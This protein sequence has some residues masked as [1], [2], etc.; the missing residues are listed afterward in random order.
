MTII[1]NQTIRKN[2]YISNPN[3][4][5][6]KINALVNQLGRK[7]EMATPQRNYATFNLPV[8]KQLLNYREKAIPSICSI[9]KVSQNEKQ[10]TESLYV[11]DRMIEA[12]VKGVEKTYPT[13]SRF[14]NTKSPTIQTMLAGIY[15]KTQV[16]DAFG[17]LCRMLIR[18]TFTPPVNAHFDPDEEIGGA[19]LDYIRNKGATSQYTK[20]NNLPTSKYIY[21]C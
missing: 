18:N 7:V 10:I 9:L 20:E 16:P 19:I 3:N 2:N 14:N 15:R 4:E 5:I 21:C 13:L 12:N 6:Y 17:P 8:V 11:L 1:R